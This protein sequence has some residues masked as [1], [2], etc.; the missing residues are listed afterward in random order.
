[1][2][3]FCGIVGYADVIETR[4]NIWE[5]IIT[6]RTY[7]GDVIRNTKR[8]ENSGNLND[9]INVNCQISIV[10]DAYAYDHYFKIKYVIWQN[11]KWKVTTVD[12]SQR[13]RILLTLGG[14]YNGPDPKVP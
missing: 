6:E 9:D 10:A 2:P 14:V 7:Y 4:P 3:K 11:S 8:T 12:P 13:P 1:M 5:S